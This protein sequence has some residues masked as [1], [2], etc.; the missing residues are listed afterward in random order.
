M[1]NI[2]HKGQ[3]SNAET[4]AANM[5]PSV[6]WKGTERAAGSEFDKVTLS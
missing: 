2:F 4:V 5:S 3:C 6:T 1:I